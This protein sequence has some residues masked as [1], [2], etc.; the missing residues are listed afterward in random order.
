M[1]KLGMSYDSV[2]HLQKILTEKV[3]GYAQD[4]KKAAGRALGTIVE[5]ITFYLLKSWG[6]GKSLSI[7][8]KIP[9]FGNPDITHNVEFSLHPILSEYNIKINNYNKSITAHRIMKELSEKGNF[10]HFGK[11]SNSL[12][13]KD[14]IIR[15][16][17]T[18][19]CSRHSRLVATIENI[20]ERSITISIVEQHLKP[21]GIFECKRVGVEEGTKKGPQTIEKAKQGSYVAKAVSSLQKVRTP[22]GQLFGIIYEDNGKVLYT[23]PYHTLLRKVICS[24]APALLK[25][26]I[27]TVGVVSN[28]GNW[29]TSENHNKELKV[30]AQSY[31]WLIFLTDKGIT[32]FV[33]EL[34]INP[35]KCYGYVR[36]AFIES[37][38][39]DKKKNCFTKVK[40]DSHADAELNRYF[41]EYRSRIES[42]LN[43]ISPADSSIDEMKEE[44]S[45]LQKKNWGYILK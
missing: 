26:F 22:D 13:S 17:C 36:S 32:E 14:G 40:M 6:L 18:I 16:A 8:T 42:W 31:D 21:Y 10:I 20:D 30:L 25:H 15:N 23:E 43:I 1:E 28:H 44:I 39:K 41:K 2:D 29:F 5:I 4:S 12:L 45:L 11:V 34:I 33:E 19:A 37:Y 3:F 35:S 9:E 27:L 38:S 7:E 24:D